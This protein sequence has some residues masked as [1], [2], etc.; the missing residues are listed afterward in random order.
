MAAG[1]SMRGL[2]LA[3]LPLDAA[4][5]FGR[6]L[7]I[8]I[9]AEASEAI[10]ATLADGY[11]LRPARTARA[12]IWPALRGS[13]ARHVRQVADQRRLPANKLRNCESDLT[14]AGPE[15][16]S[17]CDFTI[18]GPSNATGGRADLRHSPQ[19]SKPS[20]YDQLNPMKEFTHLFDALRR[21]ADYFMSVRKHLVAPRYCVPVRL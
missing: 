17:A 21:L 4:P 20:P 5:I 19:G 10:A 2:G 12:T 8:S 13:T 15:T 18:S 1:L 16:R 6:M 11:E 7:T 9:S 3:R 14:R